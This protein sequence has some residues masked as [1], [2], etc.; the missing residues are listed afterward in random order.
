MGSCVHTGDKTE[1]MGTGTAN[2]D[3]MRPTANNDEI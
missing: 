1:E 3:E 2:T